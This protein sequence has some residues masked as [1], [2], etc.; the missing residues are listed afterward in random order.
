MIQRNSIILHFSIVLLHIGILL[1]DLCLWLLLQ[2]HP[3]CCKWLLSSIYPSRLRFCARL[4]INLVDI[5]YRFFILFVVSDRLKGK[6]PYLSRLRFGILGLCSIWVYGFCYNFFILFYCKRSC[7]KATTFFASAFGFWG[8]F[9]PSAHGSSLVFVS[10][11][12]L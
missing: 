6:R 3:V 4:W 9:S 2:V 10:S 5:R 11:C 1:V 12:L 7:K 8:P